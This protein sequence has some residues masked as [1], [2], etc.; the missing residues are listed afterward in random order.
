MEDGGVLVFVFLNLNFAVRLFT[1]H[2][3]PH[4]CR[5]NWDSLLIEPSFLALCLPLY[6]FS[7]VGCVPIPSAPKRPTDSP[8]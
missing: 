2:T 3:G 5:F 8:R 6:Y 7:S 4:T 1:A